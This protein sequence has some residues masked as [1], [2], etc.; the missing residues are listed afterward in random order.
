MQVRVQAEDFDLGQE[1]AQLRHGRAEIGAV[2]S[3][4]GLVRD[5][6]DGAKVS[7]LSLE[8]YPA[9]TQKALEGICLEANRRWQLDDILL[10]H[11]VGDLAPCDQ[12]VLVAVAS[13]H[14]G[15]AFHACE[16]IMDFLKTRAPFWKKEQGPQGARW[17][18]ARESDEQA[19]ARWKD[20]P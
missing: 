7:G 4:L 2:V 5:I 14:R 10:I 1:I 12:I 15:D 19:A 6:N 20:K 13:R 8:H 9:M 16:F 11:R 18:D 17:V 3:F